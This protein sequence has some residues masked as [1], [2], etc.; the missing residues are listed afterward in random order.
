MTTTKNLDHRA[1]LN[2]GSENQLGVLARKLKLGNMLS[3]IKVTFAALTAAAT[4]DITTAAAKAAGTID[5]IDLDTSENLPAI[6]ACLALRVTASGTAASLG[7]YILGDTGATAIIPPGGA[8]AAV[9]VAKISDDGKSITFPNTVTGFVLEYMPR[10]AEP[11]DTE[12]PF[13]AP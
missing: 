6:G 4:I 13:G 12:A 10:A 2:S 5:G 11:L 7:T 1:I 3:S 9:G 8:G